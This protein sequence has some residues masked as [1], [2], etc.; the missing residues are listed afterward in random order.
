[1]NLPTIEDLLKAGC[2]FGHQPAKTHPKMKPFI[3]GTRK[4]IQII[5]L[6]QTETKL[7]EATS[8]ISSIVAKGGEVLFVSTKPQ[9]KALMVATATELDMPYITERWIGGLFTNY[10]NVS[11]LI[12]KLKDLE[13]KYHSEEIH[14]YTKKEQV[15]MRKEMEKLTKLVGG[16]KNLK[17]LPQAIFVIDVKNDKTAVVEAAK[18]KI[19][20]VA[21]CDTNNKPALVD[22]IIPANDDAIQSIEIMLNTIGDAVKEGKKAQK[23]TTKVMEEKK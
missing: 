4:G 5:D 16:L 6:D 15:M 20:I 18:K 14:K 12:K 21:V 8:F 10:R 23:T 11:K 13:K 22:Y 2:H 17:G 9:V 7:K 3:F 1:M 19:P